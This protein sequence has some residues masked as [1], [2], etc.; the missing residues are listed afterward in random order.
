MVYFV[1]EV[2]HM[3]LLSAVYF[4]AGA[5]MVTSGVLFYRMTGYWFAA[6]ASVITILMFPLGT[7]LAIATIAVISRHGVQAAFHAAKASKPR[8][9]I[10]DQSP[11][12]PA[13]EH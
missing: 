12:G 2:L 5:W 1:A 9:A 13:G 10:E 11:P 4:L 8:G 6:S 7:I 3:G